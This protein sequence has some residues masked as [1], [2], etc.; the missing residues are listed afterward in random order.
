MRVATEVHNPGAEQ[1]PAVATGEPVATASFPLILRIDS[2][3]LL[4]TVS[5]KID[6]QHHIDTF[7]MGTHAVG[8]TTVSGTVSAALLPDPKEALFEIRFQGSSLSKTTG[9]HDVALIYSHSVTEF[10]CVRRVAF[11]PRRGFVAQ[12]KSEIVTRT[13]LYFD[14]FGATQNFG[15]R[16]ISRIAEKRSYGDY[17]RYRKHADDDN[18]RG[19]EEGFTKQTDAQI[20]AANDQT[21]FVRYVTCLLGATA[22][23]RVSAKSS[24]DCIH[25]GIGF[26]NQTYAEMTILPTLSKLSAPYEIWVSPTLLAGRVLKLLPVSPPTGLLPAG[27]QEKILAAL[28]IPAADPDESVHLGFENGWLVLELPAKQPTAT[29]ASAN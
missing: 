8:E 9:V 11:D 16:I 15:R 18:R 3:A 10:N 12:G 7:L 2:A 13:Q 28:S 25:L 6:E 1:L 22:A 27:L 14:G 5:N 19:L 17:E 24:A 29:T 26:A 21:D 20:H 23:L 4:R